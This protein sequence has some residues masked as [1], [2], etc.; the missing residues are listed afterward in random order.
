VN[1]FVRLAA[2][3]C[4]CGGTAGAQTV[5][6]GDSTLVRTSMLVGVQVDTS[7]TPFSFPA[8]VDVVLANHPVAQQARLV[9][10]Q[11]RAELREAW[12]AFD[13]KLIAAWDQKR[14][15]GTDYYRYFD[16]ELKIPLPIGADVTLAFDRAMGRYFNPD[17]R[18]VGNGTFSAGISLPL[19]Q[20]IITDERRTALRQARAARDAGDADRIG[21]LNK[22]L[23]ASAKDYGMWYEM[24]RRRV[25]AQE[26]EALADFRLRAVRQRVA[27]G[28]SAPIDTIEALL[29]LQRRQVTRYETDAAFYISTLNL[30][31]YLWDEAGRPLAL[32]GDAKPVLDGVGAMGIDS[33][34]LDGLLD[35]ATRRNPDLLK[36]QAKLQQAEAERLLATQGLIPFA[37]AKMSGLAERGSDVT[38]FD[39]NRLDENYKAAL[40]VST[41]LLFLKESGKFAAAGAKL[42]FQQFERD[43][44][45]REVEFDARAAMFE[46]SNLQRLLQRQAASV[47]NARLLRDAEQI[48]FENGESTLLILNLR[49]RLVLDEAVKLAALEGKV[50]AAR[51]ALA[52]ATGDRT[53]LT[54]SR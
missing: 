15:A 47:R 49:E 24:W 36:V 19:G 23:F 32:P 29:E 30:T 52:L 35:L 34:R 18:T 8:F 41:P 48:R 51:G 1:P 10:E 50:A 38:F 12:G 37:E 33:T 53:L 22:L 11:A 27:N 6:S 26:G 16:A 3:L 45:R 46:L 31:A 39:R 25:I 44:L 28:E 40:V 21:I 9:A 54:E 2:L 17:R 20:R 43:R 42:E 13:P 7:G 4:V 5:T 14:F